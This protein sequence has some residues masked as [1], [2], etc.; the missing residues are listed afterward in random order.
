MAAEDG[1]AVIVQHVKQRDN[2]TS[3]QHWQDEDNTSASVQHVTRY[4]S[5]NSI[6]G[7]H[8]YRDRTATSGSVRSFIRASNTHQRNRVVYNMGNG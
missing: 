7:Q 6:R 8:N 4:E 1:V 3:K 2:L 5:Y